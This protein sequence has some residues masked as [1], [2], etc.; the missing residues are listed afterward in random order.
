MGSPNVIEKALGL[1]VVLCPS[2]TEETARAHRSDVPAVSTCSCSTWGP[3]PAVPAALG[4]ANTFPSPSP[5]Q[6]WEAQVEW[7]KHLRE[8]CSQMTP[9]PAFTYAAPTL[10]REAASP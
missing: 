4:R 5:S 3:S 8:K 7:R 1:T 10:S 6:S 9:L 2:L